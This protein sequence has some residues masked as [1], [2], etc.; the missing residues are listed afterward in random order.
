MLKH[1]INQTKP[2]MQI[3]GRNYTRTQPLVCV[4]QKHK[5]Q[6]YNVS[7]SYMWSYGVSYYFV[8]QKVEVAPL[9]DGIFGIILCVIAHTSKQIHT[10]HCV[11]ISG[12]INSTC[13]E[14]TIAATLQCL[15]ASQYLKCSSHCL[16][17][18]IVL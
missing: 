8:G 15:C 11:D 5:H 12:M 4:L 16:V 13:F 9:K 14:A 2:N 18:Q 7:I 6:Y 1:F 3:S 17:K 10:H